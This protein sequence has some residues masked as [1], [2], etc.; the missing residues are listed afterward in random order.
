M[1]LLSVALPALSFSKSPFLASSFSFRVSTP[2]VYFK[3]PSLNASLPLCNL[4]IPSVSIIL[5]V[6]NVSKPIVSLLEPVVSSFTPEANASFL[7][8]NVLRPLDSFP[9]PS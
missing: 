5:L 7:S 1:P 2:F 6:L 8:F 4:S 3:R 9:A